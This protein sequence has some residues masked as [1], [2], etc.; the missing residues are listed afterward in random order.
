[1]GDVSFLELLNADGEEL[2]QGNE[3]PVPAATPA[4]DIDDAGDDDAADEDDIDDDLVCMQLL[5]AAQQCSTHSTV[6]QYK[7]LECSSDHTSASE[8]LIRLYP[9]ARNRHR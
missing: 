4:S 5:P 6:L 7:S 8:L 9:V 1:M 3:A 2:A